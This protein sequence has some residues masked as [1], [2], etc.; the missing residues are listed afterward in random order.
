[1]IYSC[2]LSTRVVSPCNAIQCYKPFG[3]L[4]ENVCFQNT[5]RRFLFFYHI[6]KCLYTNSKNLASCFIQGLKGLRSGRVKA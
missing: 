5:G 2:T 4:E 6:R 1:M 3:Y